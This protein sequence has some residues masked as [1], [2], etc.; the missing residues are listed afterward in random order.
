MGF[1]YNQDYPRARVHTG[2]G[3][4][5]TIQSGAGNWEL[6]APMNMIGAV[7][8]ASKPYRIIGIIVEDVSAPDVFFFR[9]LDLASNEV[10][11]VKFPTTGYYPIQSKIR[12]A[13]SET[14]GQ[15]ACAGGGS[16]TAKI[17]LQFII[18]QR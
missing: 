18:F 7:E 17:S 1:L 12:P 10:G 2:V 9:L 3:D 4:G 16:K 11:A 6:G 5:V 15:I 14:A 13:E 8:T